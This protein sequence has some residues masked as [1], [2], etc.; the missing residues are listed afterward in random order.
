MTEISSA[1]AA[2]HPDRVDQWDDV[3]GGWFIREL[4]NGMVVHVAPLMFTAAI[5][6]SPRRGAFSYDDRWCY[7]STDAALAAAERW[8]GDYPGSEPFGWHRHPSTGRRRPMGNPDGEY[9]SP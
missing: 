9:V 3:V 6:V 2:R 1:W 4:E 5:Y 7:D 8:V